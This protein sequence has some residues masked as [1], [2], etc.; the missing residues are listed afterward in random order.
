MESKHLREE[1]QKTT[2]W[3]AG[4]RGMAKI[5]DLARVVGKKQVVTG[6]EE[7]SAYKDD[8]SFVA[9]KMPQCV[10]R[11]RN[12]EEVQKIVRLANDTHSALVPCSSKGPRTRGDTVPAV[13]DAVIVDLSGMDAIVRID[14]RNKVAMV[15]PGV[16]FG[17]LQDAAAKE[18]LR[19]AMPVCEVC[20]LPHPVFLHIA[21]AG[22]AHEEN[23]G[24][25]VV[26]GID[27]QLP[28]SKVDRLLEHGA[29]RQRTFEVVERVAQV[30]SDDRG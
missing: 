19:V 24:S 16:S 21:D 15:E 28:V 9:G 29:R 2:A 3:I 26:F 18:G 30:R 7:R 13:D 6:E 1:S 25:V 4:E 5:E 27:R 14:K 22:V 11:P 12:T 17:V 23:A 20:R 10:V 8:A